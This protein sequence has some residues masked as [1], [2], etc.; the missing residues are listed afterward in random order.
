MKMEGKIIRQGVCRFCKGKYVVLQ[1]AG[2]EVRVMHKNPVCQIFEKS[3]GE[4]FLN[5]HAQNPNRHAR[6][7]AAAQ[8]R[9]QMRKR[10]PGAAP[11]DDQDEQV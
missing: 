6:R 7:A 2:D 8:M 11:K 3:S 10:R 1:P 4:D 9:K 5:L